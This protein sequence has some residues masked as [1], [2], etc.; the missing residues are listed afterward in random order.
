MDL[1]SRVVG[2]ELRILTIQVS[3]TCDVMDVEL[4]ILTIHEPC[5]CDEVG[6]DLNVLTIHGSCAC[7]VSILSFCE[8][9]YIGEI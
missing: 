4:D 3:C 5:T 6:V 1:A 8:L 2:V 9:M 7:V